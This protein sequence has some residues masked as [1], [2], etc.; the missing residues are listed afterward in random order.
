[1]GKELDS[2]C[3]ADVVPILLAPNSRQVSTILRDWSMRPAKLLGTGLSRRDEKIEVAAG[4]ELAFEMD[5]YAHCPPNVPG[6]KRRAQAGPLHRL[7]SAC[8][9]RRWFERRTFRSRLHGPAPSAM[10]R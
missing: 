3:R 10:P 7:E 8:G 6:D 1:M 4:S 5:R 2:G 9:A